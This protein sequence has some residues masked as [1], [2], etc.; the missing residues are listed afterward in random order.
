[1]PDVHT[2]LTPTP[3][4]FAEKVLAEPE[5]FLRD[6]ADWERRCSQTALDLISRYGHKSDW[7]K[8]LTDIAIAELKQFKQVYAILTSKNIGLNTGL[9]DS[10]YLKQLS[11]QAR[12]GRETRFIDHVIINVVSSWR[13]AER[14]HLVS[15]AFNQKR[16]QLFYEKQAQLE[17][18]LADTYLVLLNGS[19]PAKTVNSRLQY[20]IQVEQSIISDMELR[21]ALH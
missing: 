5:S 6:H 13:T 21:S 17:E 19:Y 20:F 3:A 7:V 9:P 16:L 18:K 4:L 2:Q 12:Q 10:L 11:W 8:P 14:F 1:M 15:K